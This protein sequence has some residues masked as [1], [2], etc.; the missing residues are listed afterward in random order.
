MWTKHLHACVLIHIRTKGEVGTVKYI[1]HLQWIF[2]DHSKAVLLLWI[3]F[4]IYVSCLFLL[5]CLVCSMQ[6]CDHLLGNCWTLGSLVRNVFL[7]VFLSLSH[8]VSPIRC[9]TWLYQFLICAFLSN[10]VRI[11]CT[12]P[13]K[14]GCLS[15]GFW[16][17]TIIVLKT[18]IQG[19][20][21]KTVCEGV[22]VTLMLWSIWFWI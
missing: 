6:P 22:W 1:S 16:I 21:S 12:S 17:W 5:C 2:A 15:D 9:G 19:K 18:V 10:L 3:L 7:C 8:M 20:L 13:A 4:A 14:I 11:K